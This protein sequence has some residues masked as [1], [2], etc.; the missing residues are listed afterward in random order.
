MAKPRLKHYLINDKHED[1]GIVIEIDSLGEYLLFDVGN[2]KRLDRHLIKKINRIFISHTHMDHFIGFDNLL[3]NKLGKEQTVEMF[4]ISPLADNIYCKLQGYT[5][6][7]VEYEPRLV[8]RLTQYN[9]GL[10]ETFQYDIKK[11]FAKDFIS[12]K[13]GRLRHYL[14]KS[15]LQG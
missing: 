10:I 1:P 7:L 5:W 12:E 6:N 2:I 8:F 3:R 13:K 9:E 15:L 4:G 11:K 14:R